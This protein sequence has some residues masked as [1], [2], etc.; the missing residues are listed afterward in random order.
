MFSILVVGFVPTLS[1]SSASFSAS[2]GSWDK[3]FLSST[4]PV[5][6]QHPLHLQLGLFSPLAPILAITCPHLDFTPVA[7]YLACSRKC[8]CYLKIIT[9]DFT[10]FSFMSFSVFSLFV[11][12]W[13]F[14]VICFPVPPVSVFLNVCNQEPQ[15][16]HGFLASGIPWVFHEYFIPGKTVLFPR[17]INQIFS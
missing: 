3:L 7:I 8:V 15:V 10:H 9:C 6:L 12:I 17:K 11:S 1:L 16:P 4:I 14:V 5:K 13:M 2:F